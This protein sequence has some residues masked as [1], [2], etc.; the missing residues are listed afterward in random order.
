[1]EWFGEGLRTGEEVT[2]ST[3]LISSQAKRTSG[4]EEMVVVGVEK[5]FSN[6]SGLCLIDKRYIPTLERFSAEIFKAPRSGFKEE[7]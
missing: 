1:M 7:G 5:S 2:E 3:R 6:A 4:G